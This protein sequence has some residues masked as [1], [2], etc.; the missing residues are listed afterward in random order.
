MTMHFVHR[1]F[2]LVMISAWPIAVSPQRLSAADFAL[3]DYTLRIPDGFTVRLAAEP[4]LVKYPICADLITRATVR[5]RVVRHCR[6][7]QAPAERNLA[8][9]HSVGRRD[10]DGVFDRRTYS[11]N[12]R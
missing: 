8:S 2:A 11:P 7:E 9:D 1:C 3:R 6:M 12:S 10:G 5:L 4:P